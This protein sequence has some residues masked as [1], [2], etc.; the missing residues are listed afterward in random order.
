MQ[1][2]HPSTAPDYDAGELRSGKLISKVLAVG[3]EGALNCYRMSLELA[4]AETWVTPRHRHNFDQLRLHLDGEYSF[5]K[6]QW[7]KGLMV[8]YYPESM[9]YGPQVRRNSDK[10]LNIQFGG[11]SRNGFM[12]PRERRVGYDELMKKGHFEKGAF[13]WTDEKGQ[14]HNQDAYE[15]VW[16]VMRG[17]DIGYAKPRYDALI[18]MDP[19]SYEWVDDV[20]SPGIS[21]KRFGTFTENKF[22]VGF[23]RVNP[24]ATFKVGKHTAPQILFV[25]SGSVSVNGKTHGPETG[26]AL[27]ENEG[28]VEFKGVEPAELYF[29]Q[30]PTFQGEQN[31]AF[32]PFSSKAA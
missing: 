9:H 8:G 4:G 21:H 22:T 25:I 15:A 14:R 31:V 30:L 5:A 18:H 19:S 32:K 13:T 20:E 1:I 6:E 10:T 2:N 11:A 23:V 24:G 26:F 27:D 7:V 17:R 12:T 29:V 16:E 28:P 3:K